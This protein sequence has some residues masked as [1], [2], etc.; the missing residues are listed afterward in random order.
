MKKNDSDIKTFILDGDIYSEEAIALATYI[1]ADRA[2]IRRKIKS[3][4]VEIKF[5]AN[6]SNEGNMADDFINEI[7]NQ[8]CRIDLTKKNSRISKIIVTKALLS[9]AGE[10]MQ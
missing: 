3:G 10:H 6:E 1:Y 8:Q 9:A 2:D 7:L 4:K 5:K